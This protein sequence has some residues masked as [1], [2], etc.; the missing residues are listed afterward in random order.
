[1]RFRDVVPIIGS[2]T[3]LTGCAT[4]A[5]I[6]QMQHLA[7]ETQQVP[8]GYVAPAIESGTCTAVSEHR[9]Q[10]R[11]GITVSQDLQFLAEEIDGVVKFNG[12]NSYALQDWRWVPIDAYGSTAPVV[13]IS[14]LDCGVVENTDETI[15]RVDT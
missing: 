7:T 2:A 10:G 5:T 13:E 8:M 4:S 6:Q 1:M 9:F 12:G 15:P 3:L 11:V 14:V